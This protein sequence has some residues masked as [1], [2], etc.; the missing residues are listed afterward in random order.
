M[1]F[2][3]RC[4]DGHASPSS[5]C[6]HQ[7]K[8]GLCATVMGSLE[9]TDGTGGLAGQTNSHG[10]YTHSSVSGWVYFS[11]H[12]QMH[13]PYLREQLC[14]C[15]SSG[16]LSEDLPVYPMVNGNVTSSVPL[17]Y[18]K[19]FPEHALSAVNF[20]ATV[21]NGTNNPIVSLPVSSKPE[22]HAVY[23]NRSSGLQKEKM[24]F[25]NSVSSRLLVVHAS[26]IN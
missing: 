10:G 9:I 22:T 17:K 8:D 3:S 19:H 6:H 21:P 15:L 26:Y 1:I 5:S 23:D 13:G 24:A 12:G 14:S 11:K 16:F 20:P 18:L 25:P 4:S 7:E 2:K